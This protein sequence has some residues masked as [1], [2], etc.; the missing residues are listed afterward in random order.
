[1]TTTP[2]LNYTSYDEDYVLTLDLST[3]ANG[4]LAISFWYDDPDCGPAPFAKVTVN[5]PDD[6]LN[7]GEVFVKDWAENE[8]LVNYLLEQ[9][10]LTRTG[11]EVLSGYVAPAVMVPAGPLATY[12]QERS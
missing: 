8:N 5:M 3:Y 11:R 7:E 4:R 2:T 1:M 10:W 12:I 9:G 6:H